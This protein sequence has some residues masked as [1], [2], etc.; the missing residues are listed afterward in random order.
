MLCGKF[1]ALHIN[2]GPFTETGDNT[3]SAT[4]HIWVIFFFFFVCIRCATILVKT[5]LEMMSCLKF[6]NGIQ[7]SFDSFQIIAE[8]MRNL[9]CVTLL[10]R[11][12]TLIDDRLSE[13]AHLVSSFLFVRHPHFAQLLVVIYKPLL[14][15]IR[16]IAC[17]AHTHTHFD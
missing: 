8:V 11:Q 15:F 3:Q 12:G 16:Q 5:V 2:C 4:C 7:V 10:V 14:L 6:L 13:M 1:C 9:I 17:N